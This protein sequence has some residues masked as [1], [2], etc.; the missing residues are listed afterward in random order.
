M[1]R[2]VQLTLVILSLLLI[3]GIVAAAPPAQEEGEGQIYI[4][5]PGDGLI[6]LAKKFFGDGDAYTRIVEATTALA[7]ADSSFRVISDPNI[8][9]VGEKL[10]IPGLAELPGQETAAADEE[11]ASEAGTG[12]VTDETAGETA[13]E[14]PAVDMASLAETSWI[15][16]SLNGASPV[17]GTTI[18]LEFVDETKAGGSSGCNSYSTTYA[19]D[20]IRISFGQTAGTLKACLP[21][22]MD[23]EQSYLQALADAAFFEVTEQGL[24]LFNSKTTL[25]AEF[26]QASSD[27]AG[28]SWD[29]ISYNNGKGGVVT[30]ITGT[31]ITASF[32]EDGQVSGSAGCND[33]FGPYTADGSAIS[34]G[35]LAATRKLCADEDVM[36][37]E[38]AYL[39][40]LETAATYKITA[41]SMEMRTAEGAKVAGFSRSQGAG[42]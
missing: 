20:G 29:V 15:L 38:T 14:A 30:V 12:E 11:P 27:L 23:Q 3:A 7:A 40:A 37:Q 17:V 32:G 36:A 13:A 26:E 31:S 9:L 28:S 22:V 21:P 33:Y 6:Q 5:K 42:E 19:V 24:R 1:K 16:T 25:L 10:W 39:A 8:I 4:V 41:D 35:P 2:I 18:S 34:I